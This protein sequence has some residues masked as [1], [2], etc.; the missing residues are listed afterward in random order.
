M[1]EWWEAA[2]VVE[3]TAPKPREDWGA[4]AVEL[5]DGSIVR[6]GPRGGA[7]ILQKAE[8]TKVPSVGPEARVRFGLGLGPTIEAQKNLF[9]A[10]GW[11]SSP[12]NRLGKNP[13]DNFGAR[14]ANMLTTPSKEGQIIGP[15][16]TEMGKKIGGQNYQNYVQAAKS[17]EAAFMP[18]LSGAAVTESEAQRMIKASL[19]EPGDSPQTLSRKAK[20]RAMMINGAAELMGQ[21]KPFPRIESMSFGQ[22]KK[23]ATTPARA[24]AP[25]ARPSLDEIFGQ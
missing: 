12:E 1:A 22:A 5:P 11:N 17:F 9:A 13:Y 3:S 14:T 8:S 10:E 4:G 18:I 24:A 21:P 20:N 16:R 25:A 7:T 23:P 6:Y 2:P 15:L 19:P